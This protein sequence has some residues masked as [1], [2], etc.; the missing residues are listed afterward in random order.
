MLP[1]CLLFFSVFSF[2][3]TSHIEYFSLEEKTKIYSYVK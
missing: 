1:Y 3:H 2:K